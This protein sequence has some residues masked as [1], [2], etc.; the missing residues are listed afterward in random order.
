[1]FMAGSENLAQPFAPT[2]TYNPNFSG[3]AGKMSTADDTLALGVSIKAENA[4][5]MPSEGFFTNEAFLT[6][7][8]GDYNAFFDFQGTDFG[9]VGDEQGDNLINW[10]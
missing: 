5:T 3:K 10:D 6:P 1:M 9:Q 7:G 2:Y 8:N 4:D